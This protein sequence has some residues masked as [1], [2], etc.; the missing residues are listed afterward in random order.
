MIIFYYCVFTVITES[1]VDKLDLSDVAC[2]VHYDPPTN[3]VNAGQRLWCMRKQFQH[4][5]A[6]GKKVHIKLYVYI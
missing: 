4:P 1:M 3:Q 5:L 6:P 2:L